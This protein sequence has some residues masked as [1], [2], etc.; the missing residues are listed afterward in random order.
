MRGLALRL[1]MG[2]SVCQVWSCTRPR[3]FS[4][5]RSLCTVVAEMGTPVVS[6]AVAPVS[7]VECIR[8][9]FGPP[10]SLADPKVHGKAASYWLLVHGGRICQN[11]VQLGNH[12]SL[13]VASLPLGVRRWQL[14]AHGC[15][16]R[17]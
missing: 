6:L 4:M 1:A 11:G 13:A 16:T 9:P 15:N 7:L 12:V 8:S 3:T 14:Y 5:P 17:D 2:L 10:V